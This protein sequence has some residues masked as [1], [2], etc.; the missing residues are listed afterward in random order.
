MVERD[1]GKQMIYNEYL[2][3]REHWLDIPYTNEKRRIRVLLPANYHNE[4]TH[5]PVIY[6]HDGQ[7]IFYNSES[8]AG[9]SWRIIP[10]LKESKDLVKMIIV[11]IDNAGMNRINEYTPWKLTN[12]PNSFDHEL[13]GWGEEYGKFV[14]EQLKPFI[15]QEYRTKSDR[16]HTAMCGSSLGG[17]ITAYLGVKYNE[18]IGNL[19][20]FS[21]ANWLTKEQFETYF[22]S[23]S[24]K[25]P[26]NIFIQVGT[27][28][29]DETD[30]RLMLGNMKQTYIDTSIDYYNMLIQK[31]MPLDHLKLKIIADAKHEEKTW[32]N[33]LP[34][35]LNFFN[36]E[37]I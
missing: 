31:G 33:A 18:Q 14:M 15:D 26:Q 10:T 23:A 16:E 12:S 6:M 20:I 17:N 25:Y 32:A 19:G 27:Q 36:K 8:F 35:C 21:L 13:G 30:R 7:N 1:G 22:Y 29:G 2:E 34:L 11:G 28:E 5:Y 24:I 4:T 37:W 9:H 3:L